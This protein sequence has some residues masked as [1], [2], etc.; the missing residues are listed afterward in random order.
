MSAATFELAAL[1]L[2]EVRAHGGQ[3]R[4]GFH[5]LFEGTEHDGAWHF[6]DY[7]VLPPGASIG[8]HTHGDNEELYLVLEGRGTMHLEGRD[9]PV[10]AGSVVLNPCGGTH[11]LVNDSDAPLRLFVIEV[12]LKGAAS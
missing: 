4:I 2:A 3:G 12:A 10:Q 6:A 8:R 7:A 1:A 9:F 11:G 5:R